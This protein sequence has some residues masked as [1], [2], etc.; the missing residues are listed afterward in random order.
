M[1]KAAALI[2]AFAALAVTPARSEILA[3]LNY[4]SK[5]GVTPRREGI[6]IIDIDPASP[7]F[8]RIVKDAPLPPDFVAHHIYF[9]RDQTKAYV[10]SLG[11]SAIAVYDMDRLP[12]APEVAP[13]PDCKVGEDMVFTADRKRWFLS[14]M[15]SSNVIMGDA[16][17]NR[18]LAVIAAPKP[19]ADEPPR[20]FIDHPHGLT[21]NESLDLL[22][23]TSTIDPT[24]MSK[25]G[26]TITLIEASSG[27]LLATQRVSDKPAP[28][29]E[30][31]VETAFIPKRAPQTAYVTNMLGGTLWLGIWQEA[32]KSFDLAKAFDFSAIGQ[33]VPLEMEF[34]E[35][36][37]RLYV[38][39][40]KPGALNILDIAEPG[41]PKLV[42]S[43]PTGAGAHHFV[44]SPDRRYA[45]VQNSLLNLP[46][47]SDGSVT[48]VD[49]TTNAA[50]A[51]IDALQKAGFNPNCIILM[52]K[53]RAE[54]D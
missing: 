9:N 45:F 7:S 26:E 31:P 24:D 2:C 25:A 5:A 20:P 12:A 18:T 38:T 42:A 14:C 27:K 36:G 29:A 16:E 8:N 33:G 10:T 50:V 54:S 13:I 28:A 52:P 44:F 32:N 1:K 39:T 51:R 49:L 11:R 21:L 40:A 15:G 46:D 43:I 47:M 17:T 35:T 30:A 34:S 53:W 37:D 22:V 6:A 3:A 48:V 23:V 4:E 19:K 41:K